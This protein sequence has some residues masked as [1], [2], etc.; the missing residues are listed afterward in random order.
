MTKYEETKLNTNA[1]K[2]QM[3][4]E[5]HAEKLMVLGIEIRLLL[6]LA[7]SVLQSEGPAASDFF[8]FCSY[9]E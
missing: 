5:K 2:S 8:L 7:A 6:N 9:N 4:F 3:S 1:K